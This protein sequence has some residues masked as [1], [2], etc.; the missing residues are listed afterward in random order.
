MEDVELIINGVPTVITNEKFMEYASN[1]KY[2]IVEK[3]GK[4]I[5]LEK[6]EG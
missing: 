3:D 1:T 2:R 6:M 5:L 4:K